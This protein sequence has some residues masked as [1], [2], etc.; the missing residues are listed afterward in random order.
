[1]LY[2]LCFKER[3]CGSSSTKLFLAFHYL[4]LNV[5]LLYY[6]FSCGLQLYFTK[7]ELFETYQYRHELL[8]TTG[9]HDDMIE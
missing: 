1:M 7:W 2:Y 5:A 9:V 3:N 6:S 4:K 8:I